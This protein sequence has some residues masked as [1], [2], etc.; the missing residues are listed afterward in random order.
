[1]TEEESTALTA[2]FVEMTQ[3]KMSTG[4]QTM[5]KFDRQLDSLVKLLL[6][7]EP[8]KQHQGL[9]DTVAFRLSEFFRKQEEEMACL[10]RRRCLAKRRQELKKKKDECRKIVQMSIESDIKK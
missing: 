8:E 6:N 2:I 1:M 10:M 7:S 4:D 5:A 3:L 9:L